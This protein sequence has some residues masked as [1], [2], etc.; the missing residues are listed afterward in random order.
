MLLDGHYLDAVVACLVYTGQYIQTEFLVCANLLC[1]LSHTDVA[2][3]DE[4]RTGIGF[5]LSVLPFVFLFG[6]P[7]LGRENLCG[8]ILNHTTHPCGYAFALSTIPM[9][10]HLVEITMLQGFLWQDKFPVA[11]VAHLLESIVAVFLP[12]IE[13]TYE[14]NGSSIRSPFADNPVLAFLVKTKI[15]ITCCKLGKRLLS[16][17]GQFGNLV[18]RR[19]MT[20]VD[21]LCILCQ[22][23]VVLDKAQN[24]RFLH[25]FW[26]H[27]LLGGS[28]LGTCLLCCCLL[29]SST[30]CGFRCLSGIRFLGCHILKFKIILN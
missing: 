24:R 2:L 3:V 13:I 22:I 12:T 8:F 1:V 11:R 29:C 30:L 20:S 25:L 5:E 21:C 4:Q 15:Q 14:V 16:V 6:L 27:Y 18:Q 23:L 7:N 9:Y 26:C 10:T 28:L 17:I 19:L